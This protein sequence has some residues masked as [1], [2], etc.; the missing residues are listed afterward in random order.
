M[1]TYPLML[2]TE[3]GAERIGEIGISS[4]FIVSEKSMNLS[5]LLD[6][7]GKIVN[8]QIRREK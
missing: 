7:E 4:D 8:F 3:G 1:K 6:D 5:V 2:I